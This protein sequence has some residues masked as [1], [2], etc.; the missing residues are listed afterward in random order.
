MMTV[1][2]E[3]SRNNIYDDHAFALSVKWWSYCQKLNM[4]CQSTRDMA[5]I[6]GKNLDA[7]HS[8]GPH[9]GLTGDGRAGESD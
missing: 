2:P 9:I 4:M 1:A 3:T 8:E 7:T 6:Q 5:Q